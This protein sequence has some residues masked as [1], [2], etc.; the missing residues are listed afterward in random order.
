[1]NLSYRF[2]VIAALFVTCLITANIIGVKVVGLGVFILPA[3]VFLFPLSYIILTPGNVF[4]HYFVFFYPSQFIAISSLLIKWKPFQRSISL[5]FRKKRFSLN[6]SDILIIII[7]IYQ[8][9]IVLMF[10]SWVAVTGGIGEY[11]PILG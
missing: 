5:Q 10:Y 6:V 7:I 4:W 2:V 3:A 8:S 9:I 1:M 11:G